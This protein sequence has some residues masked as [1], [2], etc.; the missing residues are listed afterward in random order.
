MRRGCFLQFAKAPRTGQVKTRLQPALTA[1][2]AAAVARRLSADVAAALD[3]I[4]SG[5]DAVM[6][7]D[8]PG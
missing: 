4:P 8:E 7:A 6:C 3:A 5:W 2:Q 1:S